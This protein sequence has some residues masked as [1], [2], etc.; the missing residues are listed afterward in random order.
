MVDE[1]V[2][3]KGAEAEPDEVLLG[4]D[5]HVTGPRGEAEVETPEPAEP[6]EIE[7]TWPADLAV[8]MKLIR[9]ANF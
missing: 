3:V 7:A 6:A 4:H 5:L 9:R 1:P 8:R 2:N